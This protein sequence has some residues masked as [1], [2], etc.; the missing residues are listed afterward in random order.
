[1]ADVFR[2]EKSVG[3]RIVQQPR[4]FQVLFEAEWR[5]LKRIL[6]NSTW[7]L[8]PTSTNSVPV[9]V[10]PMVAAQRSLLELS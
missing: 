8:L 4:L 6:E 5:S 10:R 7:A 1:M 9:L 3:A 2:T